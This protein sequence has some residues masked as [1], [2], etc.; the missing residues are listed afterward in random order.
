MN[1]KKKGLGRGLS[2]LLATQE[3]AEFLSPEAAE[4]KP[5]AVAAIPLSQIEP[6]PFQ[7]RSEFSEEAL[8]ELAESIKVHG[9]I[10]PITVRKL[11]AGKYQLISGERR[12]RASK[13]AGLEEIPAY[14]RTADDQGMLEMA[15]IENTHRENLNPIEVA[16]NYQR[17]MEECNL[18]QEKLS[19]RVGKER[20]TVANYLRL[21]KLPDEIKLALRQQLLSMGHARALVNIAD[22][23]KQVQ[24]LDKVIEEGLSV[25][26]V[27]ELVR[28]TAK[29]GKDE[30]GVSSVQAPGLD[31]TSE[32]EKLNDFFHTNVEIKDSKNG[33]GKIVISYNSKEDLDRILSLL[34]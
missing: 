18:T 2:A 12:W 13:E 32:V 4:K 31:Y 16:I 19:E 22:P 15:L 29:E 30:A 27:E 1:A 34:D 3:P 33:K 10:Q 9:L 20:A 24:I 6:N 7:P 11:S 17:L 21:L 26:A 25:R 14:V 28:K 5:T 23:K 8:N